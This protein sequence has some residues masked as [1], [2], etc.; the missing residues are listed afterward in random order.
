MEL[1]HFLKFYM[2]TFTIQVGRCEPK[3][4]KS[5]S[6]NLISTSAM[7]PDHHIS[8]L[9]VIVNDASTVDDFQLVNELYA[10][11]QD[12]MFVFE[13][14]SPSICRRSVLLHY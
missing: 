6:L 7:L 14:I 9:Y 4:N 13:D 3:V 2:M 11:S 5:G 1:I 10:K 8:R 12:Y